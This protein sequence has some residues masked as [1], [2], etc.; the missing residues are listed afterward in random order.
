MVIGRE[1]SAGWVFSE[2]WPLQG[3]QQSGGISLFDQRK[4]SEKGLLGGCRAESLERR[5]L[6]AT[7]GLGFS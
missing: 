2:W 1:Q 7:E 3:A 6:V 5:I 4:T